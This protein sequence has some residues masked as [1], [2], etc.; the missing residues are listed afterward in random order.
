MY[1]PSCLLRLPSSCSIATSLPTNYSQHPTHAQ[2]L[3]TARIRQSRSEYK[4]T[5][6]ASSAGSCIEALYTIHTRNRKTSISAKDCPNYVLACIY[7]ATHTMLFQ[8]SFKFYAYINRKPKTLL[9]SMGGTSVHRK[10]G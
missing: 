8:Y 5:R 2:G 7:F 6:S 3:C 4:E 10:R 9:R 1:S